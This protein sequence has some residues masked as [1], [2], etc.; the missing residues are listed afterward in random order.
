MTLRRY[1]RNKLCTLYRHCK[2]KHGIEVSIYVNPVT[3]TL[4][5]I[6]DSLVGITWS[7]QSTILSDFKLSRYCELSNSSAS[8]SSELT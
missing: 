8:S 6:C 2:N 7:S 4:V 1:C 3:D 5:E